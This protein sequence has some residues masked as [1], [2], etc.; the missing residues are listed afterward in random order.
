MSAILGSLSSLWQTLTGT[1]Y[2][3]PEED[4]MKELPPFGSLEWKTHLGIDVEEAPSIP[5]SFLST[6]ESPCPFWPGK[7]IKETHMLCF[8]PKQMTLDTLRQY[9]GN[10]SEWYSSNSGERS[11]WVLITK[12]PIPNTECKS[13]KRQLEVVREFNYEAPLAIEAT[14]VILA[15]KYLGN[16][17]LF[18]KR[19]Q[20]TKCAEK[21]D[22]CRLV[23]KL[24]RHGSVYVFRDINQTDG[25]A[26]V[27]RSYPDTN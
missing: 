22:L 25:I 7:R 9:T 21:S 2:L 11:Y 24:D 6:L 8:I 4:V 15:A 16:I 1:G 27:I 26:G 13:F 14:I 18:A 17:S 19:N 20:L 10:S 23:V 3:P 5:E 12:K